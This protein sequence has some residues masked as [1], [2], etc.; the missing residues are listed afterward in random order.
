[1][2]KWGWGMQA[3]FI[4][5]WS[6]NRALYIVTYTELYGGYLMLLL[7]DLSRLQDLS[8]SNQKFQHFNWEPIDSFTYFETVAKSSKWSET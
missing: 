3:A 4:G 8:S 5:F 1:M 6:I 2:G 7:Q